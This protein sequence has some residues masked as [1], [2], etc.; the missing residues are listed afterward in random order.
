MVF[1]G[2]SYASQG[3]AGYSNIHE[4]GQANA[5]VPTWKVDV[6]HVH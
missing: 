3:V 2:P 5:T 6:L 1:S 4:E